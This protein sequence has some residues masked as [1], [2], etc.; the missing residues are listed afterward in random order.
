MDNS[1]DA[2]GVSIILRGSIVLGVVQAVCVFLV[3]L[4]NKAMT[5][6]ADA[7]LTGVVVAVGSIVTMFY[8]AMLTRPRTIEGIAGAAGIGLGAAL[9]FLVVDVALLQ[10]LGTYTNRW[11]EVGGGSN[12]WYHPTWWM[13]GCYLSWLGAWIFANQANKTG[14]PS[15]PGAVALVAILTAVVGAAAAALHF[16]GASFNVPTFAVAVLPALTLGTWISGFG[17]SPR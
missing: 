2:T 11:Y 16:P 8:P 12:W 9:A 7:A 13:V 14:A 10:P 3:S 15:L 1:T 5:G 6:T 4:I 17:A